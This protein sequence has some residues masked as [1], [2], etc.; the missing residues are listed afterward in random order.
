MIV[1]KKLDR[2]KQ[3]AGERMGGEVKTNTT[4]TF[5]AL[6]QEME[7]RQR[8]MEKMHEAMN[9]YIKAISKRSEAE[10]KDKTLPIAYMGANMIA[11]GEDFEHDSEFGQCLTG[12]GRTQE[13]LARSQETFITAATDSW[14]DSLDRSLVQMKEYQAAR[15]KLESRRLAYDT[16]LAKISKAKR[17]DFRI[18]EELRQQQAKYEEAEADV[19]RR[20]LDI[21]DSEA[22]SMNDLT[23]FLDAQ[24][25]YHDRCYNALQ[26]LRQEWPVAATSQVGSNQR[27]RAA[28]APQR[29]PAPPTRSRSNTVRSFMSTHSE[30]E[31]QV[32]RPTIKARTP[33][34]NSRYNEAAT[35]PEPPRRPTIGRS[36]TYQQGPTDRRDISPVPASNRLSRVPSDSLM[37]QGLRANL[38]RV[39]T[40]TSQYD[41][42]ADEAQSITTTGSRSPQTP[43]STGSQTPINGRRAPPPPP[44]S[45]STKPAGLG[46]VAP[47][48]PPAKRSL[49][50]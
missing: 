44:P 26:E 19:E 9:G 17:E 40:N 29:S 34:Y 27:F 41:V 47:P 14:L 21:K 8:G 2:F 7:L 31:E 50:T 32:E 35:E 4:D 39:D 38:R 30:K 10:R 45:R 24:L 3:W 25:A 46:K 43:L 1:N 12:M 37:V 15:K 18:E 11:H 36:T 6:E 28:P 33:S 20:M 13:R 49:I 48:P 5:K 16:S 42:F 23:A 22:E